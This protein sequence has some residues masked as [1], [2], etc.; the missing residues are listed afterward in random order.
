M[1]GNRAGV[2]A[3]DVE[4]VE[5][6]PMFHEWATAQPGMIA[7]SRKKKT[8]VFRQYVAAETAS[9]VIVCAA[10]LPDAQSKDF[11]FAGIVR[12]KSVRSPDDGIGPQTDEFFT[13]S[14][15]GLSSILNNSGM[16]IHPGDL[17]EWCLINKMAQQG[18]EPTA[19]RAKT[20]PRR[21]AIRTASASSSRI[22]GRALSFAKNGEPL[23]IL[24]KQ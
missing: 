3:S 4:A 15:G 23:D 1:V 8:A 10:C 19:K 6:K 21:V 18:T 7:L 14:I 24:I 5:R 22:I 2:T 13:V 9:P 17:V 20:G 11:F 12:S 16:P